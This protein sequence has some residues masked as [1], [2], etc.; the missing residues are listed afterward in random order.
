MTKPTWAA[1]A[2][3]EAWQQRAAMYD[4]IRD[5]F[6]SRG[7]LAVE[8]PLLANHTVTDPHI[9]SFAVQ[10]PQGLQYL[11]TSPE[12]AMKRMLAT[13]S[14]PI[15]Q[16][17]K[18]FRREEV[19]RYHRCEFTMLEW[20]RPD[21]SLE[22]LIEEVSD[23]LTTL[24]DCPPTSILSYQACF[25]QWVGINPHTANQ[26]ACY[27]AALQHQVPLPNSELSKDDLLHLLM[28]HCVE[29]NL[30]HEHPVAIVDYPASQAALAEL[31][32]T[33][34]PVA[35]RFEVFIN[36]IELGNGYQEL[37]DPAI[38]EK[39]MQDDNALR[40]GMGLP[41]IPIDRHLIAALPHCPRSAGV[42]MGVDRL[43]MI[44]HGYTQI[45]DTLAIDDV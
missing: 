27:Q 12:F 11:Q 41:R 17:C 33:Q 23:L 16:L 43:L 39:R 7:V 15:F 38:Q 6:R 31:S 18:A 28:N 20:Y 1:S 36:S 8:T 21:W 42:A 32:K 40:E 4:A 10:S 29:P 3:L 30:S 14:H 5:F 45:A 22:Q 13:H 34:P 24:L 37:C 2:T 44:K 25:D 19:G 35:K 26:Y 9:Q